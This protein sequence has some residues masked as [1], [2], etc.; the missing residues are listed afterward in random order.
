[1]MFVFELRGSHADLSE[2][3]WRGLLVWSPDGW[4][5]FERFPSVTP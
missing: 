1:M 5:L 3:S 4:E 2:V